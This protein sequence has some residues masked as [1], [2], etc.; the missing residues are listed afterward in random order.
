LEKNRSWKKKCHTGRDSS[1]SY[2]KKTGVGKKSVTLEEIPLLVIGKKQE[3]E[4][5]TVTH[6]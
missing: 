2:W 1:F 5:N 3:L 6:I 4:K